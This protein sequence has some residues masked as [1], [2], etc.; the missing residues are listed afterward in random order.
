MEISFDFV[1]QKIRDK[2]IAR[3][4]VMSAMVKDGIR[5]SHFFSHGI[6]RRMELDVVWP[7]QCI[8]RDG[9]TMAF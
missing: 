5:L 9:V 7:D 1:V 2:E 3:Q 8:D 6:G 4:N